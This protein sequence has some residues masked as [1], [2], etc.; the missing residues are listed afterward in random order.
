MIYPIGI[1]VTFFLAALLMGE[2]RKSLPNTILML[3]LLLIGVHLSTYYAF[4]SGGYLAFPYYLGFEL[5][6]P[7][8]HGPF[9]YA[10][11]C[12]LADPRASK[13]RYWPHALPALVCYAVLSDFLCLSSAEKVF[14]YQHDG[15][16]YA[17]ITEALNLG[18]VFSGVVYV[19]LS[20]RKLRQYKRFIQARF[21]DI[22]SINLAWLRYLILGISV[23][24]VFVIL[25]MDAMIYACTT[26][27]VLFIGYFGIRQVGILEKMPVFVAPIET[28]PE[29]LPTIA[30]PKEMTAVPPAAET[31]ILPEKEKYGKS[32]LR[33]EQVVAL[34]QQLKRLMQ[35]EAIYTDPELTLLTV[36]QQMA[37]HPTYLSQVI[38][39]MEQQNFYDYINGYRVEA[40]KRMALLPE[41]Q[42]FT[43]LA[44]AFE[45]GFSSKTAFNR[46]FKKAAGTTPTA[47]L[48]S[49]H[50][51]LGAGA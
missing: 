17:H 32:G 49:L 22:D 1:S 4:V 3:W 35:E 11:T 18:I 38:N 51:Q 44:L 41:N 36:A 15:V 12:S 16:G 10:Y 13:M 29:V 34:H 8:L 33:E 5:P 46:N 48:G 20:L 9:L 19:A 21:S 23:I 45:C 42:R 6:F 31:P 40:F 2:K 25:G 50:I 37:I 7:F 47:Y 43:L 26:L 27:F 39:S 14:V 30:L 28:D 24:W